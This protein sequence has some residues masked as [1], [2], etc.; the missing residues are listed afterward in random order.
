MGDN[1]V[2]L[3]TRKYMTNKVLNRKQMVIDVIHP[4][5]SSVPKKEIREQL[6][7]LMKTTADVVFVFGFKCQFGGGK[8]SGFALVYDTLDNAKKI[9][10]KYRQ[11]RQGLMEVKRTARKQRK[12]RKNRM[13]KVRGTAKAKV[14]AQATKK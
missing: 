7:K 2:T 12:E 1:T 6:A 4:N 10:P 3:R 8:S 14:G 5:R 9:E 13:K 11:V